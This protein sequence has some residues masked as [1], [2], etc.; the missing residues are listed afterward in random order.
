MWGWQ[1]VLALLAL[2]WLLQCWGTIVQ[3]R[4]YR[5]AFQQLSS[6]WSDGWMGVG[7]GGGGLKRGAIVLLVVAPDETLRR[8]VTIEGRTVFAKAR[9]VERLEGVSP[10]E[11][12][13]QAALRPK[14]PFSQALLT[15]L[16]QVE[17]VR[18]GGGTASAS[19][20][21]TAP[22]RPAAV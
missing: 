16:A 8:V 18:R 9:R 15:A 10:G 21:A 4:R 2:A 14:D 22:L 7:K 19:P 3:I 13:S 20:K 11:A 17:T 12:R 5:A 6:E 1:G